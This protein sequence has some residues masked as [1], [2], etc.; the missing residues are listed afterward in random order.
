VGLIAHPAH[1]ST[2]PVGS[3]DFRWIGERRGVVVDPLTK[4]AH[5]S[6]AATPIDP[7]QQRVDVDK[8]DSRREL[9][10]AQAM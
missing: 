6:G 8:P 2:V 9:A 4:G 10:S 3:S 5:P 1:G 7:G